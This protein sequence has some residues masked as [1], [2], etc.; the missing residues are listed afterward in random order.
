[1]QR[2]CSVIAA[3]ACLDGFDAFLDILSTQACMYL[4]V[5]IVSQ[6]QANLGL[7]YLGLQKREQ[8]KQNKLEMQVPHDFD[9]YLS[10]L[11]TVP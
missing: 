2:N 11:H 7:Q 5:Q 8:T 9:F 3:A 1:M 6:C 4:A 10:V